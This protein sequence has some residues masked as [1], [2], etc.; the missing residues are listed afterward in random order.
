MSAGAAF[1]GVEVLG[2]LLG[3]IGERRAARAQGRVLDENARLSLLQGE[4]QIAGTYRDA[5]QVNGIAAAALAQSG[6]AMGSGTAADLLRANAFQAEMEAATIR[7]SAQ[8]QAA[9][10]RTQAADARFRGDGALIEGVMGGL[11]A[12]LG[13]AVQADNR[14]RLDAARAEERWSNRVVP[15][16]DTAR[17]GV[18]GNR[19]PAGR[20]MTSGMIAQRT[21]FGVLTLPGGR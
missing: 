1:A 4:E 15:R 14:K 13:Y 20:A 8:A 16:T 17:P 9:D 12:G 7:Y 18:V 11:S 6:A 3:G 21:R 10:L 19:Q 5:R 2:S